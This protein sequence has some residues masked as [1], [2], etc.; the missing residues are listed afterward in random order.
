MKKKVTKHALSKQPVLKNVSLVGTTMMISSAILTP[1][2]TTKAY[3]DA[4]KTQAEIATQ[5]TNQEGISPLDIASFET[6]TLVKEENNQFD[7]NLVL[8]AHQTEDLETTIQVSTM[9]MNNQTTE[10]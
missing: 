9:A 3:A 1:G 10:W 6:A 8:N 4:A 7:L 2:I 5:N